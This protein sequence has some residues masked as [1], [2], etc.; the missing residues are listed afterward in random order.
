MRRV[1]KLALASVAAIAVALPAIGQN[2][3]ESLLPPGFGEPAPAR[4]AAT[5]PTTAPEAGPT[6]SELPS[7]AE[8]DL[9]DADEE[10]DPEEEA[11]LELP[12]A[13]RRSIDMV[14]P[15]TAELGGLG[16]RAFGRGNGA[17]LSILMR[18]LDAPI[19]SRWS[20][21]LLRRALLSRVP[22]PGHVHAADWVAERAW[23]LLRMGE[24]DAARMLVA[25]VDIDRFSPRLVAVAR[26]AALANAD[27]AGLCPL[28]NAPARGR[29]DASWDYAR[30]ICASLSGESSL[31]SMLLDRGRGRASRNIDYLLAEKVV[32]AGSGNRHAAQV[33]WDDVDQLTSWRFGLSAAVGLAIPERLYATTGRHVVAWRARAPMYTP[34]DRLGAAKVAA[35]MGVFSSAS[36]VDLYG[37]IAERE[38]DEGRDSPAARLRTAYAGD[39]AGARIAAIRSFWDESEDQPGGLY[40][41]RI[42]TAR[43]AA[44]LAP[45]ETLSEEYG[46]LIASM[47]SAGLDRQAAR[48]ARLVDDGGSGADEAWALLAV[49]APR[50]VVDIRY[51]RIDDYADQ[52]DA[53][54]ARLLIAALSGLGRVSL[55][56]GNRLAERYD[57]GLGRSTRWTK[58]IDRAAARGEQ[59]TVALLAAIGLQTDGWQHVPPFHL[60]HIVAA[61]KRTGN[62]PAAR[63]IAAEAL[64][65]L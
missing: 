14:G 2:A 3:P 65:R 4:P 17:H 64:S 63:M 6:T 11:R 29:D 47:L 28:A 8:A 38:G 21:I 51:D 20:A 13:A 30:A 41:A 43:A 34:E 35:T 52:A 5:S 61:L 50:P 24:A 27:P 62:D 1:A 55:Q 42:L 45:D 40:A 12:D 56:D 44:S 46:P 49:G 59:G 19:A 60:Y 37:Q 54:R 22:T 23:L 16:A 36:L 57:V 10:E 26:Q 15:M 33:E 48:W 53:H 18:R 31:S 58:A 7:G 25:S 9:A 39:D 32:G